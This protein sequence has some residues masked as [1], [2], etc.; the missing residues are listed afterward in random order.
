MRKMDGEVRV[1]E[2]VRGSSWDS[3]VTDENGEGKRR[4]HLASKAMVVE[5]DLP[6][7]KQGNDIIKFSFSKF[8]LKTIT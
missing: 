4:P 6:Y 1:A 5:F 2:K 3:L 7:G 8:N